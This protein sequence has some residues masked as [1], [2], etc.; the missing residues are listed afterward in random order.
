MRDLAGIALFIGGIVLFFV[1]LIG[2]GLVFAT[3]GCQN[4]WGESGFAHRFEPIGGC[5]IE[6][7]GAWIPEDRYRAIECFIWHRRFHA[8]TCGR[9]FL[10]IP[11]EHT[12]TVRLE[13]DRTVEATAEYPSRPWHPVGFLLDLVLFLVIIRLV[14]R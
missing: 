8:L 7:E 2:V 3:T 13:G 11:H 12:W 6:V 4:R 5:M 9:W 1:V 10:G 14:S